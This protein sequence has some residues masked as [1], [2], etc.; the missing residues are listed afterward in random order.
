MGGFLPLNCEKPT[1]DTAGFL[2]EGL[3]YKKIPVDFFSLLQIKHSILSYLILQKFY[4]CYITFFIVLLY[5][6]YYV[7]IYQ[8]NGSL[9]DISQKNNGLYFYM[10]NISVLT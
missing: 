1:A 5:L 3:G 7:I 9:Q 6:T 2:G 8:F 10:L 4:V